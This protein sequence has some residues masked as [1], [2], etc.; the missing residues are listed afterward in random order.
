MARMLWAGRPGYRRTCQYSNR[1]C[2]CYFFAD[3]H[4]SKAKVLRRRANR[5]V[6]RRAWQREMRAG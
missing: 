1:G 2:R 6:E 3:E 4:G 5:A